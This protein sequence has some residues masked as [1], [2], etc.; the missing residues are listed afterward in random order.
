MIALYLVCY[1][2]LN[3][4]IHCIL[5]YYDF[6]GYRDESEAMFFIALLGVVLA[7]SMLVIS[8]T[9]NSVDRFIHKPL[10]RLSYKRKNKKGFEK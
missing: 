2:L 6:N 4:I 5:Y 7:P 3:F 10:I 1:F 9:F 8:L